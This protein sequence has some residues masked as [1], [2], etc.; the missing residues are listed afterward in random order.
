[1]MTDYE[2]FNLVI[3]SLALVA[4][5]GGLA[6]LY[7]GIRQM[8]RGGARRAAESKRQHDETMRAFAEEREASQRRHEEAMRKHEETMR[9]FAEE[10]EAS[11]RRHEE[12]MRAFTEEGEA[13]QR[14]HEE[15]MAALAEEGKE[16]ERRHE[17][18]M[19]SIKQNGAALEA[20]VKGL[21]TVIERMETGPGEA[22][23]K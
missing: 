1:M 11:Q 14:R 19:D 2:K 6:L 5:F 13:S 4:S 7:Y 22:N 20:A 3:A 10:G 23:R 17:A 9:A 8:D 18:T 12:T 15:T 16:S 21:R